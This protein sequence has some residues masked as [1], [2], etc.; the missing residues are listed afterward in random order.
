MI[1]GTEILV[2]KSAGY[3]LPDRPK[4]KWGDIINVDFRE[5]PGEDLD[6]SVLARDRDRWRFLQTHLKDVR[7]LCEADNFLYTE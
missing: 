7:V 3:K 5:I 1:D 2:R 4:R 6:W